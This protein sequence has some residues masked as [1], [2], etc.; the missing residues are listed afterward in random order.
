MV[1][2]ITEIGQEGRKLRDYRERTRD[3]SAEITEIGK[4]RQ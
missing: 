2:E 1:I 3:G 4:V